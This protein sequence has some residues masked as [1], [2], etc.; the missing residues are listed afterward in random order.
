MFIKDRLGK[1]IVFTIAFLFLAMVITIYLSLQD[2]N[3]INR[4]A[5]LTSNTLPTIT[6]TV[7]KESMNTGA[8]GTI[9]SNG[10][11]NCGTTCS[12]KLGGLKK[13][14]TLYAKPNAFSK[15]VKWTGDCSRRSSCIVSYSSNDKYVTAVFCSDKCIRYGEIRCVG[16]NTYQGCRHSKDTDYVCLD[17][18]SS[19]GICGSGKGQTKCGYG[20]CDRYQKPQWYCSNNSCKFTCYTAPECK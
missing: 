3:Y 15:F 17:W 8:G 13:K 2:F 4:Q 6:L 16:T 5:A 20:I 18:D 7:K 9:T 11:I 10:A 14:V 19:Q 1:E 12:M